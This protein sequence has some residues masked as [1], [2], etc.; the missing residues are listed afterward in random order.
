MNVPKVILRY[1]MMN[2]M[3]LN[4]IKNIILNVK[5]MNILSDHN[6]NILENASKGF[7]TCCENGHLETAKW[8][9]SLGNINIHAQD[10]FAFM[11][12]C[13]NGH[14]ETAKWSSRLKIALAIFNS[15]HRDLINA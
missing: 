1:I 6:K 8:L 7:I 9:F 4:S 12:S 13:K 3:D 15:R 10:E 5:E 14:L 2:F 11:W